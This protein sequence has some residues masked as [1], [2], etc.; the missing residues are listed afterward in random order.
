MHTEITKQRTGAFCIILIATFFLHIPQALATEFYLSVAG[1]NGKE[2]C[3]SLEI[4]EGKAICAQGKMVIGYDLGLIR[5]VEIIEDGK[6]QHIGKLT[7][8]SI[9]RI[10]S[11]NQRAQE[12]EERIEELEK[13]KIGYLVHKL[14]F[15]SSFSDFQQLLEKQYRQ[16]GL[17]GALHLFLPLL[18]ALFVVIGFFWLLIRAFRVHILWGIGCLLLPFVSLFF[19]VFHWRAAAKPFAFTVFGGTLAVFGV[20]LFEEKRVHPVRTRI[21][22]VAPAKT[23]VK[24]QEKSKYTCKGKIYCSQ[25]T[26]CEEA[27]FYLKHC[28]GTKMDGD[29]DGIPCE[30]QWCR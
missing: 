25:M 28:P 5:D 11:S 12:Y 16:Y 18:G 30:K 19:L 22:A 4:R 1:G 6:I 20:Y 23:T 2:H 3:E 7:P 24:K 9:A 8:N 13:S 10:N 15:V 14:R 21:Q 17:N 26:S 27:K 29:H